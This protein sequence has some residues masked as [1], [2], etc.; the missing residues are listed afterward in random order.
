MVEYADYIGKDLAQDT[1]VRSTVDVE[2]VFAKA[3]HFELT[4]RSY[5]KQFFSMY[6][7][8]FNNLYERAATNAAKKWGHGDKKIDG[9]T[10]VKQD[11]IL[12]IQGGQLCWVVGT[13]FCDLKNKLN[14]LQDVDKGV[15]DV[16]PRTPLTYVEDASS[17]PVV[18]LE[19]ESGRAILH[20]ETF[21]SK[22]ILVTGCVVAV[23]G[24]E[25][26]A[27]IF[28]VMDVVYPEVAPQKPLPTGD[29]G[30]TG[31][32][33]AFVSGLNIGE[34]AD[35]KL[36]MLAQ[37]L[38]GELGLGSDRQSVSEIVQLVIA[39]DSIKPMKEIDQA[40]TKNFITTNNYG[41]KNLSKFDPTLAQRFDDFVHEVVTSMPISIMP[42]HHD[43]AEICL[44]Q[45]PLHRSMFRSSTRAVGSRISRHTNPQWLEYG[46][47]RM[48]GTLGQNVDDILK[49]V[50]DSRHDDVELALAAGVRWQNIVPTA[51]DTLYCYPYEDNDPFLLEDETPHVYFVGNQRRFVS[52]RY[53]DG[54]VDVRL[55]GVPRFSDAGEVVVLHLDTLEA[56]VVRIEA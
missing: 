3:N 54:D 23:L 43:P 52:T 29:N 47:V 10:I 26:Q 27:G 32:K 42:G 5:G 40:D 48:L 19:D 50:G 9:T 7:Y 8:R 30:R 13:V 31:K 39:G 55:I 21:F 34:V 49:Y 51:P 22:N 25:V 37:Y 6:Q 56:E 12:D 35:L 24:M 53:H 36:E 38:T 15:D 16:L 41:S 2:P 17:T 20:S 44:P 1:V 18:M 11:K 33:V 45:Q 14:I 4:T 46:G 28:E